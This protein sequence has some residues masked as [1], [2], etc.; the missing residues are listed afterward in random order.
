MRGYA[1]GKGKGHYYYKGKFMGK[2]KGKAKV[3]GAHKPTPPRPTPRPPTPPPVVVQATNCTLKNATLV[4]CEFARLAV[5]VTLDDPDQLA[6][7]M[8]DCGISSVTAIKNGR[9]RNVNVRHD[10]AT[11]QGNLVFL[12]AS[13]RGHWKWRLSHV[14]VHEGSQQSGR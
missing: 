6:I 9:P 1:K 4:T 12:T 5:N 10:P 14:S 13:Q 2:G 3:N 7:L 11:A 8:E